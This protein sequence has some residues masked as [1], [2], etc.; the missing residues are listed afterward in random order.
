[1]GD[2]VPPGFLQFPKYESP[3]VKIGQFTWPAE[4]NA[5]AT[6]YFLVD[7]TIRD[8]LYA[9]TVGSSFK[10]LVLDDGED[11]FAAKMYVHSMHP[12]AV[13]LWLMVLVDDRYQILS[14]VGNVPGSLAYE[15]ALD[16]MVDDLTIVYDTYPEDTSPDS[17]PSEYE[18]SYSGYYRRHWIKQPDL[19]SH[20]I[21]DI[22]TTGSGGTLMGSPDVS[23]NTDYDGN[24][25]RW[26]SPVAL[27]MNSAAML[28]YRIVVKS[29]WTGVP[30][31]GS[32][33]IAATKYRFV[34]STLMESR[35]TTALAT[36]APKLKYG[37]YID[38][39]P[40]VSVAAEFRV[41]GLTTEPLLYGGTAYPYPSG[42]PALRN[43]GLYDIVQWIASCDIDKLFSTNYPSNRTATLD[44]A[45]TDYRNWRK[46]TIVDLTYHGA[47]N[48]SLHGSVRE[49]QITHTDRVF[50]TKLK[51]YLRGPDALLT[52]A[53]P[54]TTNFFLY[55]IRTIAGTADY[56]EYEINQFSGGSLTTPTGTTTSK[57]FAVSG[58]T[59]PVLR[60]SVYFDN[61]V[62]DNPSELAML[63][64]G[65]GGQGALLFNGGMDTATPSVDFTISSSGPLSWPT[66]GGS[67]VSQGY[68]GENLYSQVG[69]RTFTGGAPTIST[70]NPTGTVDRVVDFTPFID[71]AANGTWTL[72]VVS[73][74]AGTGSIGDIILQIET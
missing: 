34:R 8:L 73:A 53:L 68:H 70:L 71:I 22:T 5:W 3:P 66:T 38:N 52:P 55:A 42:Y 23:T 59:E 69:A 39:L 4:P 25:D 44:R 28:G 64:V 18:S 27:A 62:H 12:V 54:T 47:V 15:D 2:E 11:L 26:F 21:P 9:G 6:G 49:V 7:D 61:F 65:P 32:G 19:I 72:Y 45:T 41:W 67:L 50:H 58:I 56:P 35:D 31:V 74:G 17:I 10:T 48:W 24:Q 33:V 30:G 51:P 43:V 46:S 63:L 13:N 57:T 1:M 20:R 60:V 16:D 36:W 40:D 37:S 14:R 29:T